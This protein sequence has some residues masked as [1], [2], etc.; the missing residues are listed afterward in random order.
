MEINGKSTHDSA[1]KTQINTF[2]SFLQRDS[3][4]NEKTDFMY[5][6]L[7]KLFSFEKEVK[8]ITERLKERSLQLETEVADAIRLGIQNT[9]NAIVDEN[10]LAALIKQYWTVVQ[11]S[12]NEYLLIVPKVWD[13]NFGWLVYENDAWRHFRV[14]QI[15]NWLSDIP[16]VIKKELGFKEPLS[17]HLNGDYLVGEDI[18]Q[19]QEKYPNFVKR[20]GD[21]LWVKPDGRFELLCT[22]VRQGIMPFSDDPVPQEILQ[23]RPCS[24]KLRP[25]QKEITEQFFHK[26]HVGIYIPTSGGKTYISIYL[27]TK[28][29]PPHL[30]ICNKTNKE[31]WIERIEAYTDIKPDE[32]DIFTYQGAV[33]NALKKTYNLGIIDEHHHLPANEFSKIVGIK[34]ITS[35]GLTAT[36]YREDGRDDLIVVLSGFPVKI[37][38]KDL[39]ELGFLKIPVSHVWLVRNMSE[40]YAILDSLVKKDKKTFIYSDNLDLGEDISQRY[41]IPFVHGK[42]ENRKDIARNNQRVVFSRVGDEGISED[43]EQVIEMAWLGNSRRQSL[44]RAGRPT[45]GKEIDDE[46]GE[47]H[48]IFTIEEFA[49]D[50]RRL[51]PLIENGFKVLYHSDIEDIKEQVRIIENRSMPKQT[52]RKEVEKHEKEIDVD[53]KLALFDEN[54]YPLLKFKGIRKIVES[55]PKRYVEPVLFFM[56]PANKD[57]WFSSKNLGKHLGYGNPRSFEIGIAPLLLEKDLIIKKDGLYKQNMS[58]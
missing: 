47:H 51:V 23:N 42:T 58:D 25:Y 24:I 8:S 27:M 20:Q 48:I 57:T 50:R 15:T 55:L 6:D 34:M 32:Y 1:K 9:S 22:L 46:V 5:K 7:E 10:A 39:K 16:D 52:R 45:H 35:I 2:S 37:P 43:V 28:I 14:N 19:I 30:I 18:S 40:K 54:K 29:K 17:V 56:E 3:S 36:P 41:S 26:S 44:Q 4:M 11:K 49:K 38:W 33:K 13:V 21:K 12:E 53:K 31:Q